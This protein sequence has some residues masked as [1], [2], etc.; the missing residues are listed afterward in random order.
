MRKNALRRKRRDKPETLH[1]GTHVVRLRQPVDVSFKL[2]ESHIPGSNEVLT[3]GLPFRRA[4]P[5]GVDEVNVGAGRQY[6]FAWTK[7]DNNMGDRVGV[8]HEVFELW[9][10]FPL[11]G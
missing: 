11:A 9:L 7:E 6:V 10:S 3:C 5:A 2:L 1:K 4:T 8:I